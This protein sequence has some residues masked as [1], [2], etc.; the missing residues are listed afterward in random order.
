MSKTFIKF[1]LLAVIVV[2]GTKMA[3][4]K[5]IETE[6]RR[7]PPPVGFIRELNKTENYKIFLLETTFKEGLTYGDFILLKKIIQ[8]ESSW[9]Q[10]NKDGSVIISSGNI[11]LAQ[12]NKFAHEKTY[13]AMGLDVKNP[14]DN[15]KFAV[16]L[17]KTQGTKPWLKWSGHCWNKP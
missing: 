7:I 17:Y 12:I 13:T 15:L 4:E 5:F 16:F 10:F 9:R 11:G 3:T 1:L 2:S 8:C 14:Y 6:L